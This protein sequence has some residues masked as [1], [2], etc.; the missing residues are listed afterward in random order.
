MPNK[1]LMNYNCLYI[2]ILCAN[3]KLVC[4]SDDGGVTFLALGGGGARRAGARGLPAFLSSV[5][6]PDPTPGLEYGGGRA[7]VGGVAVPP[8]NVRLVRTGGVG[9]KEEKCTWII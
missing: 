4:S 9:L 8:P 7:G 1:Q 2:I 5:P 3:H 6:D